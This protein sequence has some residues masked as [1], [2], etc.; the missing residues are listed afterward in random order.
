M[1]KINMVNTAIDFEGG[2]TIPQTPQTLAELE[3][4][5]Y[6]DNLITF[7]D[8]G[9]CVEVGHLIEYCPVDTRAH[10]LKTA[11][12]S[13]SRFLVLTS[14]RASYLLLLPSFMAQTSRLEP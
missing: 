6:T 2:G 12:P 7:V 13:S 3:T 14:G 11:M 8:D 10:S 9:P 5:I 4:D 1:M